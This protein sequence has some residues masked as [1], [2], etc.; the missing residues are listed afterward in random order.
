[1]GENG[2]PDLG[3]LKE[4]KLHVCEQSKYLVAVVGTEALDLI[5]DLCYPE[6]P[7][8]VSIEEIDKLVEE[9]LS[10]KRSVIAE[11]L[12]FKSCKQTEGQS[13]TEYLVQ[14]KKLSKACKFSSTEILKENLRDQFVYGLYSDRIRQRIMTEKDEDLTFTRA[15]ELALSL[16]AARQY[17]TVAAE[18]RR[19]RRRWSASWRRCTRCARPPRP[20]WQRRPPTTVGDIDA[21]A[22]QAVEAVGAAAVIAAMVC[23]RRRG[24]LFSIAIVMFVV[25]RATLQRYVVSVNRTWFT[26]LMTNK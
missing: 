18:V 9:H 10:P 25:R 21:L 23:T 16:E 11:R 1:M 17:E 2:K 15:T 4:F 6:K 14:L 8:R 3:S 24:A 20:R 13:I 5:I 7:E 22:A 12:I 26:V 19:R